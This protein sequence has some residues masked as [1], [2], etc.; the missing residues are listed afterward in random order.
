[1]SDY[2]KM[3]TE[4]GLDLKITTYSS[5]SWGNAYSEVFLSQENRPEGMKYFDFV[6][7][8]IHGLRIKEL[9]DAKA[10]GRKVIGSYCVLSRK[11]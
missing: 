8:E 7:S 10:E 5:L 2:T 11:S 9:V 6:M 1:M 3:W 4:L